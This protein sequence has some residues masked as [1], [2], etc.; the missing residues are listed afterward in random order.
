MAWPAANQMPVDVIKAAAAAASVLIKV[1]ILFPSVQLSS[2]SKRSVHLSLGYNN[3]SSVQ[4]ASTVFDL[5]QILPLQ[6]IIFH[7]N[8]W[9]YVF[10]TTI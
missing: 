9:Y 3:A 8:K 2:S 6:R 10:M 1:F 5:R 7:I 4:M